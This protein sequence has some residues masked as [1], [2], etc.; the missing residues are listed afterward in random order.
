RSRQRA[1]IPPAMALESIDDVIRALDAIIDWAWTEKSRVGYFAGLYRRVTRAVK[2]G[3]SNG[4]F[5]NGPLLA[6]LDVNFAARY[7]HAFDQFRA[8]Q[9]PTRS[10]QLAFRVASRWYPIVVQQLLAGINA[11]INLDLGV[12][13][14]ITA[15]G[16]QLPSLQTDF[17]QIN[18]VLAGEV[19]TVE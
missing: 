19:G 17:N 18:A 12:A 3:I 2:T 1:I 10:W 13:A 4:Q 14:A 11:H 6:T 16:E 15:P 5:Q 9:Q 7:L 8:G